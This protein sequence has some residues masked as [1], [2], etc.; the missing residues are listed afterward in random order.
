MSGPIASL[1]KQKPLKSG[2][3]PSL[4]IQQSLKSTFSSQLINSPPA[5]KKV[6]QAPS[7]FAVVVVVGPSVVVVVGRQAPLKTIL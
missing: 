2:P 4:V 6:Q 1:S 3:L 5:A 7:G